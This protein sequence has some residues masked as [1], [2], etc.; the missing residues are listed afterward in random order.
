MFDL[1]GYEAELLLASGPY[2]NH[3][4]DFA[5]AEAR[6]RQDTDSKSEAEALIRRARRRVSELIVASDDHVLQLASRLRERRQL[7]EPTLEDLSSDWR[8][9][10]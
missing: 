5:D 7:F 2:V 9:G 1:A 8:G 4:S 6:A 10:E 3:T